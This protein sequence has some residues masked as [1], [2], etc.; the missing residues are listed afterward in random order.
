V[1]DETCAW[2][3]LAGL[4]GALPRLQRAQ[5]NNS[6]ASLI[7]LLV[8]ASPQ[9]SSI[10]LSISSSTPTV[11]RSLAGDAPDEGFGSIPQ[12]AAFVP[13]AALCACVCIEQC[14]TMQGSQLPWLLPP[15]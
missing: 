4:A 11:M 13:M 5:L 3:V 9:L 12:P 6:Q 15:P 10:K 7:D 14:S 8:A 1:L 2:W